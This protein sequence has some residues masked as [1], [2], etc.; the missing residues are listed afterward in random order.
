MRTA[1]DGSGSGAS[2]TPIYD[3]LYSEYQR[4]F[5]TLPGDRSGEESLQFKGFAAWQAEYP[6]LAPGG[7]H[8]SAPGGAGSGG[9]HGPGSGVNGGAN[10]RGGRTGR[11]GG[12]NGDGPAALPPGRGDDRDR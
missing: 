12:T 7:R 1:Q 3:A 9:P 5:R 11:R 4:L 10:G 8:R 6:P 2:N